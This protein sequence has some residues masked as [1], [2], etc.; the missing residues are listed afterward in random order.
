LTV[1]VEPETV[2]EVK[3][4]SELLTRTIVSE[5]AAV[6]VTPLAMKVAPVK[7][8]VPKSANGTKELPEV[9]S[10]T[11]HSAFS[12]QRVPLFWLVKVCEAVSPV[13][14]FSKVVTPPV[15]LVLVTVTLITLPAATLMPV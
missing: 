6:E 12:P 7:V 10:S 14:T 4:A 11:I 5:A 8:T 2:V 9:K 1:T 15:V 13:L 3:L